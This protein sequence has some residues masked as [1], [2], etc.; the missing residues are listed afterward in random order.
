MGAFGPKRQRRPLVFYTDHACNVVVA[1]PSYH[2]SRRACS[3]NLV[4]NLGVIYSHLSGTECDHSLPVTRL[5]ARGPYR[6]AVAPP[7][8][9]PIPPSAPA[10]MMSEAVA[11]SLLHHSSPAPKRAPTNSG[12]NSPRRIGI[13]QRIVHGIAVG[14]SPTRQPYRVGLD[15][16]ACGRVIIPVAVVIEVGEHLHWPGTRGG[17]RRRERVVGAVSV[18]GDSGDAHVVAVDPSDAVALC[19]RRRGDRERHVATQTVIAAEPVLANEGVP[20]APTSGLIQINS[21]FTSL[22]LRR[23]RR[24][25]GRRRHRRTG[26]CQ[27]RLQW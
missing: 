10:K 6:S 27:F 22:A 9:P 20:S 24:A 15:I 25:P 17:G 3:L 21:A 2:L 16:P 23:I 11:H 8:P 5:S 14:T 12:T 18:G 19:W 7:N 4:P 26:A 1:Q 13:T